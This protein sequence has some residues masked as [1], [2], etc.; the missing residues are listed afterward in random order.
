MQIP[1]CP[2]TAA[3]H[4]TSGLGSEPTFA[5]LQATP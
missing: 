4:P 2:K 1:R 3:W 5:V